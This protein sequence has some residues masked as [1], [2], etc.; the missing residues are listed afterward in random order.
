MLIEQAYLLRRAEVP[1]ELAEISFPTV[2]GLRCVCGLTVIR[3]LMLA[4]H[5]D[6]P[7]V[8]AIDIGSLARYERL[9]PLMNS[10]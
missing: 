10:L 6:R 8:V 1:F 2:D 4:G 9:M 7:A 5:L 3:H